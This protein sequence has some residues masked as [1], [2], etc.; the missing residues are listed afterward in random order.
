M[1]RRDLIAAAATTVF[2]PAVLR[3]QQANGWRVGF[4]HP[5]QTAIAARR[6]LAYREGLGAPEGGGEALLVEG[7]A[8]E[9]LQQLPVLA[10]TLVNNGVQAICAVSP[11]AIEAAL[12]ASRTVPVIAVDLESDPVANGWAAS[13]SHPGGRITGIFLDLPDLTSKCV[14]LL[15]EAL[16][17]MSKL[18]LLSHPASGPVQL[19]AARKAAARLAL[20]TEVFEVS[21][22]VDFEATF[23]AMAG[24]RPGGLLMLS[25]PL[26]ASNP[27]RLADLALQNRLPA[28]NQFTEF[29]EQG[30]YLAY[31]PDLQSLFRQAGM[32]TRRILGGFAAAE[33]PL[34]RPVRFKLVANLRTAKALGLD[35]QPSLFVRADEV[36]E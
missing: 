24:A 32:M 25:S 8:N 29:A 15:R 36:I 13:F 17:A 20:R 11:P 7:L 30:G 2:W 16:P 5:G 26:F 12:T 21:R 22:S 34:D 4:L 9:Q 35:I 14:Q 18:A 10:T 23:G 1:R 31:G 28:M 19:E 3:S 33:M 6:L 27:Q